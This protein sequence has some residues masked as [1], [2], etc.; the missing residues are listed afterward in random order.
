MS[1]GAPP[2][3]RA[4]LMG[5]PSRWGR[6]V[7]RYGRA[8][9]GS[10]EA[11]TLAR[12]VRA[13]VAGERAP[14][15]AAR[16]RRRVRALRR[17]EQD[18]VER[19]ARAPATLCDMKLAP[20]LPVL[21]G[22]AVLGL[23]AWAKP[24]DPSAGSPSRPT[25]VEEDAPAAPVLPLPAPTPSAAPSSPAPWAAIL[26]ALQR[27]APRAPQPAAPQPV[28]PKPGAA[29]PSAPAQPAAPPFPPPPPRRSRGRPRPRPPL[30]SPS[31]FRRGCP[32]SRPGPRGAR[33]RRGSPPSPACPRC[34]PVRVQ[35]RRPPR[36]GARTARERIRS[37]SLHVGRGA[38]TP[39]AD[40]RCVTEE[41]PPSPRAS[42]LERGRRQRGAAS[43]RPGC[44]A[45]SAVA[46]TRPHPRPAAPVATSAAA[47]SARPA[48]ARAG[49][50]RARLE[51][52]VPG[53]QRR[54][55]VTFRK[56]RS[57]AMLPPGA[58]LIDD[59]RPPLDVL[60]GH[61]RPSPPRHIRESWLLLRLSPMTQT[62][63]PW[64]SKGPWSVPQTAAADAPAAP[65]AGLRRVVEREVR[66]VAEV[67]DEDA[68]VR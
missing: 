16:R 43:P 7:R 2:R 23:V 14:A 58:K 29:P 40:S 59:G 45:P 53:R 47:S 1:P 68:L 13:R 18:S 67:L 9:P 26:P 31:R 32:R 52:G 65:G 4:L 46:W 27:M 8:E 39:R 35:P 22:V 48:G 62:S 21:S 3:T 28:A 12:D 50:S 11:R 37:R 64:R 61:A 63:P 30:R 38:R 44:R 51:P 54:P 42:Y 17:G 60:E 25:A 19:E 33:S 20:F 15:V 34:S 24:F 57:R 55:L 6:S 41:A 49:T 10:A 56:S 5:G 66:L 36:L